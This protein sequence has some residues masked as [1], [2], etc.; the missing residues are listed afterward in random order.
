MRADK[1]RVMRDGSAHIRQTA[2]LHPGNDYGC[3]APHTEPVTLLSL[4]PQLDSP[5]R[6]P[7]VFR[8]EDGYGAETAEEI[9]HFVAGEVW[10]GQAQL[11]RRAGQHWWRLH[12]F[13]EVVLVVN[14]RVLV[15][16]SVVA[17]S[18][19]LSQAVLLP[20]FP[21]H[22]VKAQTLPGLAAH[23]L[24]QHVQRVRAQV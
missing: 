18:Q 6:R 7:V 10:V 15:G 20:Q 3:V 4:L 16:T 17:L 14:I 2:V 13:T 1:T 19:H 8:G 22:S 9:H 24:H 21:A 23:Q 11:V 12:H 5:G